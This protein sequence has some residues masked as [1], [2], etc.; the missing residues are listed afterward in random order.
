SVYDA[1]SGVLLTDLPVGAMTESVVAWHPDG[2]RLAVTGSLVNPVI[3]IWDVA[4]SRKVAMLEGHV[5]RVTYLSFH[6]D[7]SL[8]ASASWDGTLRLWNPSTGRQLMQV[9]PVLPQFSSDGRWLGVAVHGEQ[10][11]MLEVTTTSEYRTLVSSLGAGQGGYNR[12][13]AISPDGQLLAQ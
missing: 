2:R 3:Q 4:A 8:L 1:A 6:P 5:Q 7:G 13:S 9:L 12:Y 10:A 11:Q